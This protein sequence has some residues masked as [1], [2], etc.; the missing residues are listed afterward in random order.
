ME[1]RITRTTGRNRFREF[2]LYHADSVGINGYTRLST[3]ED[4]L[5]RKFGRAIVLV[6]NF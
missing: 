6:R 2:N 1:I 3:L 5:K 4:Y